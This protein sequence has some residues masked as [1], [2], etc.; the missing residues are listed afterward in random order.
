MPVEGCSTQSSSQYDYSMNH[1]NST[2]TDQQLLEKYL[3][4]HMV[5]ALSGTRVFTEA[6]KVWKGTT[7]EPR[8]AT[9]SADVEQDRKELKRL[10]AGLG[11]SLS[12]SKKAVARLGHVMSR[13]NPLSSARLRGGLPGQFELESLH[14]AVAAKGCLWQTLDQLSAQDTRINGQQMRQLITRAEDQ[15][16]R[17][18]ALIRDTASV[19]FSATR[20]L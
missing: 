16:H 5:A 15:Q 12:L 18:T 13:L 6:H 17:I 2:T 3:Q 1:P 10:S 7:Y 14:A 9:L 19:R 4:D 20:T 8:L 11:V